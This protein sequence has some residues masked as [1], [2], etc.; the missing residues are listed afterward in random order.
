MKLLS[1]L[2]LGLAPLFADGSN[3]QDS[4]LWGQARLLNIDTYTDGFAPLWVNLQGGHYF[5]YA[6]VILV[7]AVV[8]AFALHYLVI[9]PKHFDH[10]GKKIYA[11]N[12]FIRAMHALAAIS[13][14][15]L[16]PTGAIMMWGESFGG[17]A[18][19][20]FAK[21]AHGIATI[22]FCIAV[23]PLLFSWLKSMLPA[24]YDI[25]WMLIVGGYLSKKKRPV[26][27]GKF[28]AGQKSWFWIAFL[29]G[30][31][32]IITG[33]AM[34]FMDFNGGDIFGISQIELLRISAIIHNALGIVCAVFLLVHIYMACFAIA[35]AIHSMIHGYKE[36]EEVFILHHE[37][38][39]ELRK[40]GKIERSKY[41]EQYKAQ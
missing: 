21:N 34:Y 23:L 28:N 33:A 14:I 29:G 15:I 3:Q 22:I 4:P 8:V 13:W 7:L 16:V 20:R 36:E 6:L 38:Y 2:L 32:M 27:A 25:K 5:A 17:G 9:G 39:K 10:H 11:F 26:P 1:W 24:I 31:V 12:A 35:G 41:E 30:L 40:K 37:W 19:V 18:F